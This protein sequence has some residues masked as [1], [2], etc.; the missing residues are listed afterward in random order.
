MR[1]ALSALDFTPEYGKIASDNKRDVIVSV[2]A[3]FVK[4]DIAL[5]K[6]I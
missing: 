6:L 5:P 3:T 4:I 1:R 2:N